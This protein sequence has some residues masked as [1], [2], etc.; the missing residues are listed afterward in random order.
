MV[1]TKQGTL[2][3]TSVDGISVIGRATQGVRVIRLADDDEDS[4]AIS[5]YAG[6]RRLSGRIFLDNGSGGGT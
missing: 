2:I 3:R 6:E 1:S 5:L 4:Y